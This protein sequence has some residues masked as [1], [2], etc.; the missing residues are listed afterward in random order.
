MNIQIDSD[1][2]I[3]TIAGTKFSYGFF[4]AFSKYGIN[5]NRPLQIVKR[6]D[7]TVEVQVLES[8]PEWGERDKSGVDPT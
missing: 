4:E 1:D 6:E 5:L 2:E 7:G 3:I 8:G